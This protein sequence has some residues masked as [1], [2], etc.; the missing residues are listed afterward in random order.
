MKF[1]IDRFEGEIA[2]LVNNITLNV[3][4]SILPED[5]KEGDVIVMEIKID[6]EET[7]R[8]RKD[9]ED[10]LKNLRDREEKGD[11]WL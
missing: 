10:K 4:R 5:A 8:L 7:K 9:L 2:V 6:V 11:I 1:V 3:P